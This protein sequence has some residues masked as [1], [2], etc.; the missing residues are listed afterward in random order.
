MKKAMIIMRLGA[1]FWIQ[2]LLLSSQILSLFGV[3]ANI[4]AQGV[5]NFRLFYSVFILYG[6]MVMSITLF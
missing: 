2:S 3:E 5:G 6:M 1:V 4:I